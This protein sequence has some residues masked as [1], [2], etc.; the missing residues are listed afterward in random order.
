MQEHHAIKVLLRSLD[1]KYLAGHRGAWTFAEDR[2]DA[3][4]F[5]YVADRIPEQLEAL[6]C[7]HGLVLT[8]V[9]LDPRD[10]Y[11]VCDRCGRKMMSLKTFFDGNH[12]L[13]L[14]CHQESKG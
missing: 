8:A 9:A 3:H 12:Y 7:R 2:K 1:G 6:E 11:E 4:V 10:R 5:D 14:D 13:C